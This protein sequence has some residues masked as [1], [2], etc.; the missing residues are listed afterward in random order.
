MSNYPLVGLSTDKLLTTAR[1]V[2]K[3]LD[4]TKP[5]P[6]DLIRECLAIAVQAPTSANVQ[7]WSSIVVTDAGRSPRCT[8]AHGTRSSRRPL[9]SPTGSRTP[10]T[11]IA[12]SAT[13][14]IVRRIWPSTSVRAPS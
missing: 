13:Y 3:R 9:Q 11:E 14:P 10:R 7:N 1:P 4:L 6:L 12:G 2:R 8:A 5:V